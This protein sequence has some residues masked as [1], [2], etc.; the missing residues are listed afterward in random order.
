MFKGIH[1]SL[2]P[3]PLPG[4]SYL[5]QSHSAILFNVSHLPTCYDT[6]ISFLQGSVHLAS[7]LQESSI[8]QLALKIE[9]R[10]TLYIRLRHTDPSVTFQR[11]GM[12]GH[13]VLGK[14][15]ILMLLLHCK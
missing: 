10:G 5:K 13:H 8:H 1:S 7:L 4:G 12:K 3:V 2:L 15:C 14:H 9:P 11:Q 6:L